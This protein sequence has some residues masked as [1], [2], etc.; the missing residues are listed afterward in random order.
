[1]SDERV[2]WLRAQIDEGTSM[3]ELRLNHQ[4]LADFVFA[5]I[6]SRRPPGPEMWDTLEDLAN[7]IQRI[8]RRN[9]HPDDVSSAREA[10]T[11]LAGIWLNTDEIDEIALDG[12]EP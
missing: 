2:V 10:M 8:I 7:T 1:M 3:N 6:E 4:A 12:Q 9:A 5:A 11:H